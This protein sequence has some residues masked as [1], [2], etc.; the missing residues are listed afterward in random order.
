MAEEV[1]VGLTIAVMFTLGLFPHH[2]D[3]AVRDLRR[4][5]AGGAGSITVVTAVPHF[6]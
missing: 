1:Y 6:N 3:S 5:V 2:R 4:S